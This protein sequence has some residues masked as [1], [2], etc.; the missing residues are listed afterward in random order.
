MNEQEKKSYL[1]HY[2]VAKEKG[3]PFFPD[4]IFKDA[5][6]SLLVFV[7]LVALAYFIGVPTEPRANPADTTYTPKPEWYFL[8][9]FQLLKYFPGNLEVVGVMVIPTLAIVLLLVLPFIDRSPKRHFLNRPVASLVM[10]GAVIGVVGLTVLSIRE[11]PP[12]QAITVVDQAATLYTKNCSNCHGPSIDVPPETDLHELIARGK[13][14]GMPAWGG[15]LS[16]DEID[17]LAGFI[18]SPSGSALYTQQCGDCHE[19]TVL[20]AGNPVELQR[21]LDDGPDYPPHQSIEVQDW[22]ETLSTTER[23]SLLNFL[24]APDGQRLFAVNCAGCHGRGVAF[25]G[26]ETELRALISQGGQHLEMPAWR[27]TLTVGDLDVLAAYVVDPASTPAGKTLFDQHC[28]TCHGEQVPKAPDKDS[29]RKIIAG[30][31]AHVTMPV[32]GKILTAEQLNAL[33]AYTLSASKGTGAAIGAQIFIDNCAACHGQFGEGGP[34]PSRADDIIAPISSAEFLR[35]RDD[36]TLRN[37][38]AQGQPNFGMSPFGSAYGGPLNDDQVDAVVAFMRG[39]EANPPVELPPEVSVGQAVLTGAQVFVEICA[40]CHG[41]DGEGG[42]G[43]A[44]NDPAFQT[45][46]DDQA[47]FDTIS[48]GHEATAMIAW[49]DILSTDQITQ[50]VRYLRT[51]KPAAEGVETPGA[52]PRFSAQILPLLQAKCSVCHSEK[53]HLGG[54]DASSYEAVM[55][56]GDHGPTVK[57]GEAEASLLAQRVSG[58]QTQGGI[59]PPG[60]LLPADEIQLIVD[61]IVAGAPDN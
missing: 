5:L 21:V 24:A 40:R 57:P 9:L 38:V 7:V 26:E 35:T 11:A 1:D 42:I 41:A 34:N 36:L 18:A 56:T 29:A 58:T 45:R 22:R 60:G 8:F 37:I 54:W 52:P 51:L 46:Y 32:W 3:V 55:T 12:P 43:P 61:W 6:A 49:G 50:L 4:I 14:E 15:D 30:G 47:L 17:A 31:G 59:M 13:H 20:A 28:S 48:N 39:W 33:V 53:T 23:N 16:T 2:Y 10:T 27:G 19:L 44:L 25:A